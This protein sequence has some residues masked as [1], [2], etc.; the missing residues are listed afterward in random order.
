MS[1]PHEVNHI[2]YEPTRGKPHEVKHLIYRNIEANNF[3]SLLA[4]FT[5]HSIT[6]KQHS[7]CL[8]GTIMPSQFSALLLFTL[9]AAL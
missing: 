7:Y 6:I 1:Y 9:H 3:I 8:H 4:M 2:W 5:R